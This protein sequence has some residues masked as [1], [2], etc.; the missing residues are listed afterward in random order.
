[1]REHDTLEDPRSP[2]NYDPLEQAMVSPIDGR[3]IIV[4]Y[5][6]TVVA[7]PAE[8]ITNGI[9]S[10][11]FV[12][13]MLGL[14]AACLTFTL[15]GLLRDPSA[16]ALIAVALSAVPLLM[17]LAWRNGFQTA[18]QGIRN[19]RGAH[20]I[21]GLV[22]SRAQRQFY[23]SNSDGEDYIKTV[24]YLAVDDRTR[25]VIT[26]GMC[27]RRR[28]RRWRWETGYRSMSLPTAAIYTPSG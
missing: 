14:G 13:V 19:A 1:V 27:R 3:R 25:E 15:P 28:T 4:R 17:V 8:D 24:C 23:V 21:E 18:R 26:R 12:L 10:S 22:V 2:H 9:Q 7:S 6:S 16:I 5:E 11:V 20:M